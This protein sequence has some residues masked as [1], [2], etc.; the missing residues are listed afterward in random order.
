MKRKDFVPGFTLWVNEGPYSLQIIM[1]VSVVPLASFTQGN[2]ERIKYPMIHGLC[3]TPT[4]IHKF[5][6]DESKKDRDWITIRGLG[7][8]IFDKAKEG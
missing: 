8:L 5:I 6:Y 4:G 2:V 3:L 7:H 1:I